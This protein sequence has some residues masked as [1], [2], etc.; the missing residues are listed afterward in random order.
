MKGWS[1]ANMYG[2]E[3]ITRALLKALKNF[4]ND[5]PCDFDHLGFCQVH[6][7]LG[8]PCVNEIA[9]KAIARAE[10]ESHY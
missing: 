4:V 8:K 1:E 6:Y 3:K 10:G 2:K 9:K 7:L 5:V